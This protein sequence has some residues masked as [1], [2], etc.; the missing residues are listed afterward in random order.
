MAQGM[1][2]REIEQ[3]I[4]RRGG[5]HMNNEF[6]GVYSSDNVVE[7]S[8]ILNNLKSVS[9]N[10]AYVVAN[11][12]AS[13]KSGTHWWTILNIVLANAIYF[14]DS[15]GEIGFDRFILQ[16]DN[17]KV[18][19]GTFT[20]LHQ[21]TVGGINF[22]TIGFD[23]NKYKSLTQTQIDGLSDAAE[24]F[25]EFLAAFA[26]YNKYKPFVK[27]HLVKDALQEMNTSY[28]GAFCLYLLFNL[29][30]PEEDSGIVSARQVNNE[31]VNRL[32]AELFYPERENSSN[33]AI[34]NDLSKSIM[35]LVVLSK[36]YKI[37]GINTSLNYGNVTVCIYNSIYTEQ[38]YL[39]LSE[40]INQEGEFA[41]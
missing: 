39:G 8:E 23:L 11:T 24:G 4:E 20:S 3:F 31:T 21:S 7:S 2:S 34:I 1:S 38:K 40:P 26:K 27:I 10:L 18:L 5:E 19:Q 29:F 14:F 41:T 35:F 12:D 15:F 37:F 13:D 33:T 16:D 30:N 32:V 9:H 6:A 28:C 22:E 17:M 36:F 25:L